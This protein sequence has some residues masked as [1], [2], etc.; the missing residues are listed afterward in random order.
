MP[1]GFYI[2]PLKIYFY[3]I[4]I[5]LGVLVA[6]QISVMEAKRRELDSEI[7]WDM[8]P[9]LL[10]MGIIGARLWHVFTPSKSMGVGPE[11][12]FT[13]PIEILNTR[14]GGLG[15]PGGVI[16]GV[17]ALLVYT[18]KKKLSFLTW[19]DIVVPGLALAQAIGRWGNFFN[20]ELYGPPSTLPWAI[21][22]DKAHRLPGYEEFSTFHPMFLYESLWSVLNF[23]LLLFLG[24]IYQAK[25]KAG[26]LFWIY[27]IVYPVGRFSLEFIRLDPSLVGGIN[28]NQITMA[29]VALFG[30]SMLII[31]HTKKDKPAVTDEESIPS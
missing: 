28:A 4:I 23:F 30:T 13:H 5:M 1:D 22:I 24:R 29:V 7:V 25:L 11:Y 12:Y 16:G 3:G 9:W 2:G 27:L 21:F 14:Q 31:N 19:A 17:I 10:I 8:I 18:R 20:Q 15:I 6:V 26:D